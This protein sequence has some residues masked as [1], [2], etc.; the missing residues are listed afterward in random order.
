MP[1]RFSLAQVER[2]ELESQTTGDD[3]VAESLQG[4]TQLGIIGAGWDGAGSRWKSQL[5]SRK[6]RKK[7]TGQGFR[8]ARCLE[9]GVEMPAEPA[10]W[11]S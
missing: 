7:R 5:R 4:S 6:L 8:Q 11:L 2:E 9:E 10:P 1:W 3:S